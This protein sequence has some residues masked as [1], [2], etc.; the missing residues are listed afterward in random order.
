MTFQAIA[1]VALAPAAWCQFYIAPYL[2]VGDRYKVDSQSATLLLRW[3][4]QADAHH[5]YKVEV[6]HGD[7]WQALP[8]P[9]SV[10]LSIQGQPGLTIYSEQLAGL[11]AGTTIPYHVLVDSKPAFSGEARTPRT[12]GQPCK[13][14]IVGDCGDGSN[15][16]KKLAARMCSRNA[17]LAVIVGDIVYSNGRLSEYL[18]KFFPV[19][20][21]DKQS[22]AIGGP[23]LR[24][25][26]FIACPGNHDTC[27]EGRLDGADL[28][29]CPD[30]LAYYYLWRQPLNGPALDPKSAPHLRGPQESTTALLKAADGAFP[31]M[32]NFSLDYGSAHI[33]CLDAN[34]YA[35]WTDDKLQQWLDHDL[36][37]AAS[38]PWRIVVFHQ[39]CFSS[40]KNHFE[41]QQM[42]VLAPIFEKRN[43]QVVFSG[44]THSYQRSMPIKFTPSQ[45]IKRSPEG[46]IYGRWQLDKKYSDKPDPKPQG[47]IY[48]VTGGGG[49]PLS[50]DPGA[51]TP[52]AWQPF[53]KLYRN[54]THCFSECEI[55]DSAFVFRQ[56]ADNGKVIDA[57]QL[58][59]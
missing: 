34:D 47:V 18:E 22:P 25:L 56:V 53:T 33:V 50:N 57:F 16:E 4:E 55:T 42:R 36:E 1:I 37:A 51:L 39:A 15:S 5:T 21:A 52:E 59:N 10:A 24:N 46:F 48:V 30:G 40:D 58:R 9:T 3:V 23:M 14:I 27:V 6:Q 28:A 49:A 20:N 17:D 35:D 44:H 29:A 31:N 19:Y 32:S 11:S 38:M 13:L 45:P 7:K 12:K 41:D 8:P 26:P 2:Q 54:D 43:V